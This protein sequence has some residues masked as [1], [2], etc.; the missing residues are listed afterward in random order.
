ML[1]YK[2]WL[3]TRWRFLIGLGWASVL[4]MMTRITRTAAPPSATQLV[5]GFPLMVM[6]FSVVAYTMLA[7]AGINTQASFQATKGLHGSA[8]LTLSLPV[9]RLELLAV[10]ASIGWLQMA[11][12]IAALCGG[13]WFM[14][15]VLRG[16]A[17]PDVMF[18][19]AATFVVCISVFY[20]FAVLVATFLDDIWRMWAGMLAFGA[21]WLLSSEAHLPASLD[22]VRAIGEGSPLL[23]HTMPW[24]AM[25][26]SVGLA[27]V[28]FIAAWKIAERREF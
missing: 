16:A 13:G 11:T 4:L 21:A 27:A 3:E 28:L 22:I 20:S 23:A 17:T 19:F 5:A 8:L 14:F 26:F 9:S 10:R 15:P 2:G 24:G 25:A 12:L 18:K 7:G 6:S 1:W